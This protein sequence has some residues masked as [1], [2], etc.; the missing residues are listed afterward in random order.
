MSLRYIAPVLAVQCPGAHLW[1]V[2]VDRDIE[3]PVSDDRLW[4]EAPDE[5]P[6]NGKHFTTAAKLL[7]APSSSAIA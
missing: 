3:G 2:V 1:L 7:P 5:A 6:P 4:S